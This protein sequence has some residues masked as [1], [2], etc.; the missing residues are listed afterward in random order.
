MQEAGALRKLLNFG[1]QYL[2]STIVE[3][4]ENHRLSCRYFLKTISNLVDYRPTEPDREGKQKIRSTEESANSVEPQIES[5][6]IIPIKVE[7][8]E[9]INKIIEKCP[10]SDEDEKFTK[11]LCQTILNIYNVKNDVL[12]KLSLEQHDLKER[13]IT[14]NDKELISKLTVFVVS[15]NRFYNESNSSVNG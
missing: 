10:I 9:L 8:L 2:A 1:Q 14:P 11:T 6:R 15:A 5:D 3:E 7:I 12:A 4:D 13:Q